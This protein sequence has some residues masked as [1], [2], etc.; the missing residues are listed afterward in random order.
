MSS[1]SSIKLRSAEKY[2]L[3]PCNNQNPHLICVRI[4]LMIRL[5][6][7]ESCI[8]ATRSSSEVCLV[9]LRFSLVDDEHPQSDQIDAFNQTRLYCLREYPSIIVTP[10]APAE[11]NRIR[12]YAHLDVTV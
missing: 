1:I 9:S 8:D 7:M 11:A 3:D 5:S 12:Q 10:R 4:A 6:R 2:Q